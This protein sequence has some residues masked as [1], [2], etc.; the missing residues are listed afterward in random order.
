[1]AQY[2]RNTTTGEMFAMDAN[3]NTVYPVSSIPA[4]ATVS[5]GSQTMQQVA[6]NYG[7]SVT[8]GPAVVGNIEGT[9]SSGIPNPTAYPPTG[10]SGTSTPS[11]AAS[12]TPQP[13]N[14]PNTSGQKYSI[15][16]GYDFSGAPS[17]GIVNIGGQKYI[18]QDTYLE[19]V[20]ANLAN[21]SAYT[22]PLK[23]GPI[24]SAVT[25]DPTMQDHLKNIANVPELSALLPG[26]ESILNKALESGKVINPNIEISPTQIQQ[27][28]TQA[29]T[30]L[31]PYFQERLGLLKNDIDVSMK[32]LMEDYQKGIERA[33]DPF[34]QALAT[35]AESEAQ[36]GTTFSSGR[37]E[38]EKRNIDVQQNKLE[39]FTSTTERNIQDTGLAYEKE[40]GSNLARSLNLPGLTGFTAT[41]EG[42]SPG[43]TRNVYA[44][45]GNIPLGNIGK[46][47]EVALNL[48]KSELE[49]S[50]R[51]NRILDLS[52]LS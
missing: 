45:L 39:D 11:S 51:K 32:R 20:P 29:T 5:Q 2:F 19:P 10:G 52:P 9:G 24:L 21:A 15:P 43:A 41:T 27:F 49:E 31:E 25:G 7:F 12:S 48:R 1:M 47:K 38:R 28:L 6:S 36:A 34:K 50:F 4:G 46:E 22:V 44:P 8:S 14:I 30:E 23:G 26:L 37:Q 16:I 3:T 42:I 35:Q 33:K 18:Y 17:G 40:A 13:V